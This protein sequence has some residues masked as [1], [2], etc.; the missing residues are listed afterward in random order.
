MRY[1]DEEFSCSMTC[2]WIRWP[3]RTWR[4]LDGRRLAADFGEDGIES[5]FYM[6]EHDTGR[7]T[8]LVLRRRR[9]N[10]FTVKMDMLVDFHGHYG[11]DGNPAMAVHAEVD[12]PFIGLLIIRDKPATPAEL[13]EIAAEFVDLSAYEA[14]EPWQRHGFIFRPSVE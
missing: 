14:P 12:V 9:E 11:G 4:E 2:E 5:T 7:R 10:I 3:V 1:G 13:Q 6:T 8:E